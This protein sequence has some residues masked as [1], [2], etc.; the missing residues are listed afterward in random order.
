[1]N[2]FIPY[3]L[4]LS[5]FGPYV[6]SG[7]GLRTEQLVIYP[8][9]LM[10]LLLRHK[11]P[12]L[13]RGLRRPVFLWI[14]ILALGLAVSL[15]FGRP[16]SKIF[17]GAD[18]YL[19]P[20]AAIIVLSSCVASSR[21]GDKGFDGYQLCG[22]IHLVLLLNAFIECLEGAF[23]EIAQQLAWF[24][25]GTTGTGQAVG[26]YA[27]DAQRLLGIFNQPMEQG[28]AYG[29]GLF[30]WLYRAYVKPP[31]A[32]HYGLLA[33]L[34]FAGVIG[35]SKVFLFGALPLFVVCYAPSVAHGRRRAF[36]VTAMVL[37]IGLVLL[38]TWHYGSALARLWPGSARIVEMYQDDNLMAGVTAG[39]LSTSEQGALRPLISKVYE[40]SP[41]FGIGF[42]G[43]EAVDSAYVSV[44]MASGIA[45][46]LLYA[47][48][49][50]TLLQRAIVSW[51]GNGLAWLG[52]ATVVFIAA[53]GIGV[54]VLTLNRAS[55][56]MWCWLWII[57]SQPKRSAQILQLRRY[58]LN[59][60]LVPLGGEWSTWRRRV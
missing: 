44:Y 4:V 52:A 7:F 36:R 14:S 58:A 10:V 37:G 5:I 3:L 22:A 51:S 12:G 33:V 34:I 39:R 53:V 59:R 45:G 26:W 55:T 11:R 46:L 21:R 28:V 19:L 20:I 13:P 60:T 32:R 47:I 29:V 25:T 41:F 27:L 15:W 6:L 30:C 35:T 38:A 48:L 42:G 31:G 23:P 16:V 40:A 8:L 50:A 17:A 56:L 49:L 9:C 24:W 18:D 57:A 43:L 2:N 1:M 54:P